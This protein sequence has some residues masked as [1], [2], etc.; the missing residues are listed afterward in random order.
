MKIAMIGQKGLP[1]TYGGIERHVEEIA[2]RLVQRGHEV[3]V[4]CRYD[5]T[6]EDTF[7][8][9]IRLIRRPSIN[10][11]HLGTATHVSA[12]TFDALFRD[13][14]VVHFHALGPSVFSGFPRL[15]GAATVVTVHGLDWQREKWG[16]MVSW[17]LK[18]CEYPAVHFPSSTV[19]VSHTLQRYFREHHG[20]ETVYVPNGT[21]LF[22]MRPA[23]NID[24]FGLEAGKYILFVGRLVPEKGVHYLAEA[25]QGVNTDMKL[26]IAG[27]YAFAQEYQEKIQS[28]ESDRIRLLGYVFGEA[29][30]ELWSNAY[31]VVLPS[32]LEGLSIAL[33][34]ALSYG[35]CVLISDIPENLEVAGDCAMSFQSRDVEDLRGKMQQLID[36]PDMVRAYEAKARRHVEDHFS[37]DRVVDSLEKLYLT[38]RTSREAGG[39]SGS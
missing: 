35:R 6:P 4:Y 23:S 33:L 30:A 37:W 32:T 22:E 24:R 19:V 16:R 10:T 34:E 27:G 15:R 9:G 18:R 11:K 2:S 5:Y 14:D 20:R 3:T 25:Y 1:A 28:Y 12:S 39:K 26:A 31:L 21:S 13:Y 8:K 7:F 36:N 17:L 38:L 29:L